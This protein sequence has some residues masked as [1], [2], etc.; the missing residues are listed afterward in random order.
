[1]LFTRF[2]M[3]SRVV[4]MPDVPNS[5]LAIFSPYFV[6]MPLRPLPDVQTVFML[7][8]SVAP[9]AVVAASSVSMMVPALLLAES[10][11]SLMMKLTSS[12]RWFSNVSYS[13]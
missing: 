5:P 8:D 2:L 1:M 13:L 3:V 9:T 7:P 4:A 10:I 12:S 11:I 6:T